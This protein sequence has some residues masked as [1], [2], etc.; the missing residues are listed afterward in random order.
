MKLNLAALL[1]VLLATPQ[2]TAD[3]TRS[4]ETLLVSG[5][6]VDSS[7]AAPF[8]QLRMDR[9]RDQYRLGFSGWTAEGTWTRH[10]SPTRE[11]MLLADAT[12]LYAHN[13]NRI[14][15]DGERAN[16]LE[17]DNASY[18]I[19]SG[20]RWKRGQHARSEAYVVALTEQLGDG[21]EPALA[22]YWENPYAGVEVAHTYSLKSN[23]HPL[24]AAWDGVELA[25]RAETYIGDERW[26]RIAVSEAASMTH[27]R[28][29]WRQSFTLLTGQSLNVV[30]RHLVGG[31][32][33]ALGGNTLYGFRYGEYRVDRAVIVSAG[34]DYLLPRNWRIGVRGSHM[35]S[36]VANPWGHAIN[37]ST[38]WR[39][40]GVNMGLGFPSEGDPTVYLA[41]VAPLYRRP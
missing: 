41:L 7:L 11:W 17:Y 12:P 9:G 13:S 5:A 16:E 4:D 29:D 10:L 30:N 27:G 2:T 39:T 23:E 24:V 38:T 3:E 6:F 25:I 20:V 37:A 36:N 26:S 22:A 14:Y 35:R 32:W 28:F 31:S 15:V 34:A 33:D 19:R 40:F 1:V 8:L 21:V 18:R